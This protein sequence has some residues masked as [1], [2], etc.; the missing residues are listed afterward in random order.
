M[1]QIKSEIL[2]VAPNDFYT[3]IKSPD[4]VEF[5]KLDNN[6]REKAKD[7]DIVMYKSK[8]ITIILKNRFGGI[9]Q[10]Q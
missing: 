10:V 8:D 9:G 4:D 2:M 1:L 3:E 7:A 6:T 5:G